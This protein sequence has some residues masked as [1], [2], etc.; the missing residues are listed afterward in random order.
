MRWVETFAAA[1]IERH[2]RERFVHL[3]RGAFDAE[4]LRSARQLSK[5]AVEWSSFL[6]SLEHHVITDS[7]LVEQSPLSFVVRE[8]API[9]DAVLALW[10]GPREPSGW[11]QPRDLA[12]ELA[13]SPRSTVLVLIE[14]GTSALYRHG[15]LADASFVLR[16]RGSTRLNE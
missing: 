15:E 8:L 2:R 7:K 11:K 13:A 5:R 14:G 6:A 12:L 10:A 9:E 3:V 4:K 1:F 16:R